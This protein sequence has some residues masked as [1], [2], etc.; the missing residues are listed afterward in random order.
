MT[1]KNKYAYRS[2]ISEHQFRQ[3][4]RLFA[5]DLDAIQIAELT[6]LNRNTVNRYLRGIRARI[7]EFCEA[8]APFAGEV[9]VDE[10]FFGARRVKGKRGR[11][12]YGKTVVFGVFKR[13]GCVY[14]EIVPD[15][16]RATLQSII[17][18]RVSLDSVIYSDRWRGYNGLVD[19]GYGKHLRIDH[20]RDE[21]ARGRTHIHGIEGFW[22]FAK[23]RLT[24][25]RGMSKH[26]FYLH[27]KECEFRFNHR[28]QAL[29]PILLKLCRERPLN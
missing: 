17:R 26:T 24:R 1:M 14:T 20:S 3:L 23:S 5:L 7:A 8:Q 16:S 2:R 19:V 11:G 22:G 12:A 10:S 15:C 13:N 9:E 28:R 25:F 21:F 29:Y 27:L 6:G 18:G 4:V